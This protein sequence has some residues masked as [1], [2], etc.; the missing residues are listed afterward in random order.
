[1]GIKL[2]TIDEL[3]VLSAFNPNRLA[4][5]TL[6][7]APTILDDIPPIATTPDLSNK[8]ESEHEQ[9]LINLPQSPS[10]IMT[11]PIPL[12]PAKTPIKRPKLSAADIDRMVAFWSHLGVNGT[13]THLFHQTIEHIWSVVPSNLPSL[14]PI[15][16][17]EHDRQPDPDE[18]LSWLVEEVQLLRTDDRLLWQTLDDLNAKVE[19]LKLTVLGDRSEIDLQAQE[20]SAATILQQAQRLTAL[21]QEND[22]L[23]L[24]LAEMKSKFDA[25]AAVFGGVPS[26]PVNTHKAPVSPEPISVPRPPLAD[27]KVS[28]HTAKYE[29]SLH[30]VD[31]V[32]TA[33]IAWNDKQDR[34][35]RRLLLS[36][37]GLKPLCLL[38]GA[39]SQPAIQEVLS[40]RADE[41]AQHHA[42]FALGQRHNAGIDL[43]DIL[44]SIAR[45]EL[46]LDNWQD[47]YR[48]HLGSC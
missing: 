36:L 17:V 5:S 9:E 24:E 7:N 47:I 40:R 46:R 21:Q 35:D 15:A 39:A 26:A 45:D 30:M 13:I 8:S 1:M 29:R 48:T 27:A 4:K 33:A 2:G 12:P 3:Q 14:D 41:L 31:R 44:R 19:D 42:K 38:L 16:Q 25:I 23:T 6:D 20:D 22:R 43:G 37:S 11:S 34:S 18:D 10:E 32:V 28:K